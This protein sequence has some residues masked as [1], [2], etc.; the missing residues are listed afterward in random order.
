M[1]LS[2]GLRVKT[3]LGIG[4][5]GHRDAART[6]ARARRA[7]RRA[8]ALVAAGLAPVL[9]AGAAVMPVAVPVAAATGVAAAAAA[10]SVATA[11][12]AKASTGQPVLVLLQNGETTAPESTVLQ[13]VGYTVTQATPSTWQTM[14]ASQFEGYAA[15]V[16]GDP[17]S[18]G[19]CSSLTPDHQH[20]GHHLAG[21]GEREPRRAGHRAGP[22]RHHGGE[23][24]GH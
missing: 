24:A 19:T 7:W 20:A 21:R 16:I 23:H 9:A 14:S 13:N 2:R 15:L 17:S 6:R 18:G 10:A 12:P 8:R 3:C 1:T 5:P 11:P 4:I 22:A